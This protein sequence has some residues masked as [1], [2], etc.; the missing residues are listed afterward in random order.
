[1]SDKT[2]NEMEND[3]LQV[4]VE[5]LINKQNETVLKRDATYGQIV[6]SQQLAAKKII[7]FLREHM[8]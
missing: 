1:M 7:A 5:R 3:L 2:L 8:V 6:Y 4:Q